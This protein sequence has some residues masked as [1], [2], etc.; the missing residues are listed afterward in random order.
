MLVR[1]VSLHIQGLQCHALEF[2]IE[3]KP[4]FLVHALI[5]VQLTTTVEIYLHS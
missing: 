1:S 2:G 4:L 5:A 3:R